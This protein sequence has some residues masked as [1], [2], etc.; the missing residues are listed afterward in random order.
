[1][2]SATTITNPALPLEQTDKYAPVAKGDKHIWGIYIFLII[3]SVIE[4]YSASSR[5]VATAG[6]GVY[7]TK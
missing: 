6:M 3:I 4:L 1:M 5:E 2:Q 7:G